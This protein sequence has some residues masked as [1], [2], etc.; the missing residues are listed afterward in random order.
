M[1][2]FIIFA[3][4]TMNVGC[5]NWAAKNFGGTMNVKLPCN[6]KLYDVTWKGDSFWYVTRPM[7]AD[8]KPETYVFREKSNMGLLEG[9]VKIKEC[10]LR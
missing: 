4:L 9:D 5:S 7:R 1:K 2:H 3:M 8:E 6:E 10:R